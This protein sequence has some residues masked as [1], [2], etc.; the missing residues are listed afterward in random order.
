[1]D[2]NRVFDSGFYQPGLTSISFDFPSVTPYKQRHL[3][4]KSKFHLYFHLRL[5][6]RNFIE[7]GFSSRSPKLRIACFGDFF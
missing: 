2:K 6:S 1:M 7:E 5:P 3:C 4:L